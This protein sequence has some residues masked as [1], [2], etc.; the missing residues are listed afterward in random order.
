M[1]PMA[2]DAL[3]KAAPSDDAKVSLAAVQLLGEVGTKKSLPLLAKAGKSTNLDVRSA[4]KDAA[5]AILERSK[6][7]AR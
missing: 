6:T 1:G 5:K 3:I 2:E 7:A 4:A